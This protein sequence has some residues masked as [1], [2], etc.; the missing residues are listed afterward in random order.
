MAKKKGKKS[1]A[2]AQKTKS[3]A[4]AKRSGGRKS[5][6]KNKTSPAMGR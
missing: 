1:T 6:S 2:A 4:G 5:R 3:V